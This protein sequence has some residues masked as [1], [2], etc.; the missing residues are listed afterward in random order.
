MH[1]RTYL[2]QTHESLETLLWHTV[3]DVQCGVLGE[4]GERLVEADARDVNVQRTVEPLR[5]LV[6]RVP[7]NSNHAFI[8]AKGT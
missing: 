8:C 6:S 3:S 5:E 4:E 2:I 1:V 7:Q